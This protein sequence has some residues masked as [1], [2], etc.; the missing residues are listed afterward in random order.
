MSII[1]DPDTNTLLDNLLFDAQERWSKTDPNISVEQILENMNK[2]AF[3][4]SKYGTDKFSN[5]Q[6]V[7]PVTLEDGS[8]GYSEGRGKGI[9]QFESKVPGKGQLGAETAANRLKN[10]LNKQHAII[11]DWVNK[12]SENDYDFRDLS[13]DQQQLLFIA[14]LLEMPNKDDAEGRVEANFA[15]VDTDRELA[16]YWAQYH[17]AG[18]KLGTDKYD[19]MINKFLSD[20]PFYKP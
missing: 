1:Q 12:L 5:V 2:I 6:Q 15:G 16:D 11:P 7:D 9:F 13:V 19:T 14:N 8:Y 4:E 20:M 10:Y 17:Q 18:T 3:V